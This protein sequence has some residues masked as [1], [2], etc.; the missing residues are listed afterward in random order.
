[1]GQWDNGTMGQWDN[2]TGRQLLPPVSLS[3]GLI[4][5]LS[6]PPPLGTRQ[7]EGIGM[8]AGIA[9]DFQKSLAIREPDG[10]GARPRKRLGSSVGRAED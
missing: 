10:N 7:L 6:F 1:M 4:V 3:P 2:E 8:R 5:S 9:G